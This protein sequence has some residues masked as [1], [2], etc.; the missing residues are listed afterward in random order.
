MLGAPEMKLVRRLVADNG[1]IDVS[2]DT[3][4]LQ[5]FPN[6][7]RRRRAGVFWLPRES[8]KRLI[9][10]DA[11]CPSNKGYVVTPSLARRV[12]FAKSS[13][14]GQSVDGQHYETEE[15]DIYIP[16]GSVRKAAINRRTNAL[17]RLARKRGRDGRLILTAAQ[18][19]AGR[20]LALDYA[21]AGAGHLSTQKYDA[22]GIDGGRKTDAQETQILSRITAKT[23]L[24]AAR[25]ALGDGLERAVI[26]VCCHEESLESVERAERWVKSSG[27]SILKIGLQRLVKLYGTEAGRP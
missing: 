15:R 1:V 20:R 3:D 23:R 18:V 2:T 25:A 9:A 8:F 6:G 13:K 7:D 5:V 27:L 19:E 4:A 10:E 17:E 26:A 24:T 11:I 14:A 22:A 12:R 21:Q 16:E